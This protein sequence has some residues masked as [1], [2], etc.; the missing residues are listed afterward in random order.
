MGKNGGILGHTVV[1]RAN[2][3]VFLGKYGGIFDKYG[4]I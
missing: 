3:V 1:F 4:G 2:I